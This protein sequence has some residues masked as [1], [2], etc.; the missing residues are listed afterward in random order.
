M[1]KINN[2]LEVD[3]NKISNLR[4]ETCFTFALLRIG[5]MLGSAYVK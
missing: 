2:Y 5:T 3:N 1:F 4:T